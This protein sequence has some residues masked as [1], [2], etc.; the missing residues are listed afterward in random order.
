MHRAA[1]MI[2]DL[3]KISPVANMRLLHP[4]RS[5]P[6]LQCFTLYQTPESVLM[7]A[8]SWL[9]SWITFDPD[10]TATY[11]PLIAIDS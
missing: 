7:C 1:P 8:P 10:E 6:S 11:L 5:L 4:F 3:T 9:Y 2:E